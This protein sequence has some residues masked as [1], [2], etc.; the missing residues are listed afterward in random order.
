[1]VS[2]L[3]TFEIAANSERGEIEEAMNFEEKKL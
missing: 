1:M 2:I 3:D